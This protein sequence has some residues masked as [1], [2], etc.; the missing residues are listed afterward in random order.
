MNENSNIQLSVLMPVYN[1]S[2]FLREAIESVLSQTFADFEFI[3]INDGS[4][5]NSLEVIKIFKDPRIQVIHNEKN[6]GIIKS[7]N[8]GL[9]TARGK[10]IANM[11]ADDICLQSRF[12]KQMMY[13]NEHPD[14]AVLAT[15]LVLIDT[16]GDEIGLWAEDNTCVTE[17]E[18]LRTLPRIN[19]IGQPTI[20]MR[21]DV[22]REIM[23]NKKFTYNEDWGL[24]LHILSLHKKIHKLPETL[25]K[26]RQHPSSTTVS[27]NK[28]GVE[29]KVV[30]FKFRYL[31]YKIFHNKFLY[32]DKQV[33]SSFLKE[34]LRYILKWLMP[35]IYGFGARLKSLEKLRYLKQFFTVSKQLKQ[36]K[37][38][39]DHLY[40][41]PFYHMG[42]AERVHAS[43][44][45]AANQP[46]SITF[47]TSKSENSDFFN[48]F[49]KHTTLVEIDELT[50]LGFSERW[51]LK[52]IKGLVSSSEN[53]TAVGCNSMFFYQVV[54]HLSPKIKVVDLLHAFVHD[55]ESGPEKWSLACVNRINARVVINQKTK[56]DFIKLYK[57]NNIVSSNVSKIKFI[58]NYVESQKPLPVKSE[59]VL[60]V[61]YVGRGGEEKRVNLI[62][63]LAKKVTSSHKNIKFHF[64]GNV[65]DAI[66]PDLHKYCIFHNEVSDEKQLQTIYKETHI[67]IIASTREGFP[68]VIM[69][70]MM[71]GGVPVCTNVGGISEHVKNNVNGFLVDSLEEG[72]IIKEFE[73]KI[74]DLDANR[75]E[76]SKLSES[77]YNYALTHFNKDIFFKSWFELLN[78]PLKQ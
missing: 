77:A 3:I 8:I 41:F 45:E 24:W 42:G 36:F 76:L 60:N 10:Y 16:K 75:S 20:I 74:Y 44:L 50:K 43:I 14:V 52:K 11:D 27:A 4:T 70:A 33:L 22:V 73:E 58:S 32:T 56:A 69:E 31:S 35:R 51:L 38:P 39:V 71:Q 21:T 46:N 17:E 30:T 61:T 49:S 5:D 7:R 1:A 54:P 57:K 63:K 9:L 62:A 37:K 15:K 34:S 29:K 26:Y 53:A 64:V 18:I 68:M 66:S 6:L 2:S 65:K 72:A 78:N 48:L 19:C 28:L 47:I 13:L 23:Y 55:Y 59:S 12:E 67:L 40:F 25:L